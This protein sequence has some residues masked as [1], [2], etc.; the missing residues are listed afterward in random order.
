MAQHTHWKADFPTDYFGAQHLPEG[1]DVIVKIKD[2]RKE[3][4]VGQSGSKEEK[5]ILEFEPGVEPS[6][7]ILNKTN[8]KRIEKVCGSPYLDEWVGKR[9]QLYGE[10]VSA[11]GDTALAI[12]VREFAPQ[13]VSK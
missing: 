10:M 7:M 2:V 3:I 4:V 6:K 13:E 12:R 1:K 11:V 8:A 5:L 9:I